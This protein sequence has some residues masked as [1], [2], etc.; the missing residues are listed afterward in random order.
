MSLSDIGKRLGM[1]HVAVSKR[2][3]KLVQS[4]TVRITAGVN[5]QT[6]DVKVLFMSGYA[7]DAIAQRGVLEDDVAII[8]KPFSVADLLQAVRS[9]LDCSKARKD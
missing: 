6:L 1:S 2:L 3:D 9:T 7:G 5:A 4:D 8:H